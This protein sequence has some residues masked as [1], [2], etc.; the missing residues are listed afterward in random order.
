MGSPKQITTYL[1]V[2]VSEVNNLEIKITHNEM[3]NTQKRI[4]ELGELEQSLQREQKQFLNTLK[5]QIQSVKESA[6]QEHA[7]NQASFAL[8]KSSNELHNTRPSKHSRNWSLDEE[9]LVEPVTDTPK[10]VYFVPHSNHISSL[11]KV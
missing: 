4:K 2:D 6:V 11:S 1:T 5:L 3:E 8:P 10:K 9:L 7:H